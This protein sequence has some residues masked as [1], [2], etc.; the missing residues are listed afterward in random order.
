MFSFESFVNISVN[1]CTETVKNEQRGSVEEGHG[2]WTPNFLTPH[3][4]Y[5]SIHP[6]FVVAVDNH[7]IGEVFFWHCFLL[8]MTIG[9]S[10][11]L[12]SEHARTTVKP[13]FSW[14][15]VDTGMLSAPVVSTILECG[16][17]ND[18]G[19]LSMLK[20]RSACMASSSFRQETN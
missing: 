1:V 13:V 16:A 10:F 17:S 2:S 5:I 14:P 19:T 8:K 6:S 15:V 18:I 7:T 12:D 4:H 9:F 11:F 3:S 20:T